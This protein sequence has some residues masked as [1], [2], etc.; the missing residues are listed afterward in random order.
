MSNKAWFV[1][2]NID[3]VDSPALV[4]Y[5]ERIRENIRT[6]CRILPDPARMRPHIKTSKSKEVALMLQDAGISRFKCA[7]IAEA[8]MLAAAGAQDVL[9]AYQ[10][11]G[12]KTDRFVRLIS[13]FPGT[14]FSCLVDNVKHAKNLSYGGTASNTRIRAFIDLNVGMN[15]TGIAPEQAVTLATRCHSFPGLQIVGLHAYDGHIRDVDFAVRK[16]RCDEV[17][18]Q[19]ENIRGP[20]EDLYGPMTIVA[21]GTPTFPIHAKRKDVQCS[22]GTFVYWDW[23]YSDILQEQPYAYAAVLI[24]RVISGPDEHTIC[25]DLGHKG[26]ASENP[27]DKRVRFLNAPGYTP[28]GHSE[29]HLVLHSDSPVSHQPGDVLYGVPYHICPTCALY[30]TVYVVEDHL[31]TGTWQ[32]D[33]RRRQISV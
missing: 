26:I 19:I 12:P 29:E 2:D 14:T 20:I 8:E 30:D 27:L 3:R 21:G 6:A 25:T 33:A 23:G 31:V 28:T 11:V 9:L 13:T 15:R 7:T 5:P 17:F 10:P 1:I 22:P 32:I 16:Q 4:V 18:S 24:T